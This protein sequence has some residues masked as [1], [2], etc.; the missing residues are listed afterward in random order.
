MLASIKSETQSQKFKMSSTTCIAC[1]SNFAQYY[2]TLLNKILLLTIIWYPVGGGVPSGHTASAQHAL[3][4]D[5][6]SI[7]G[8]RSPRSLAASPF[9]GGT[10]ASSG[11]SYPSPQQPPPGGRQDL[12]TGDTLATSLVRLEV[13]A[14]LGDL[15]KPYVAL[16]K[17]LGRT[18]NA[19]TAADLVSQLDFP[20]KNLTWRV[21]N[22]FVNDQHQLPVP[23]HQ[24]DAAGSGSG[25]GASGDDFDGDEF[26]DDYYAAD[27]HET[28]ASGSGSGLGS[29][30]APP[31]KRPR[32]PK[33]LFGPM[34]MPK[35]CQF[36][37][38][39]KAVAIVN[40]IG[41]VS[42]ERLLSLVSKQSAVPLIGSS[43]YASPL[44][45]HEVSIFFSLN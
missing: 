31:R 32:R 33:V 28:G 7:S 37:S 38:E 40:L 11:G 13:V 21:R 1:F 25:Y 44:T 12:Y 43:T 36:L 2:L 14:I 9:H 5:M 6:D 8:M 41:D 35:L 18:L 29:S 10:R 15:S 45:L 22:F 30:S 39:T 23:L 26:I 16:S 3:Q 34:M 27:D 20:E 24:V 4:Q 19:V 42:S 17:T